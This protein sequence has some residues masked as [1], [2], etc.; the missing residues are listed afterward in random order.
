MAR[1]AKINRATL[2]YVTV[3]HATWIPGLR[4]AEDTW[5][6]SLVYSLVNMSVKTNVNIRKIEDRAWN[7]DGRLPW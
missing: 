4:F 3:V 1:P 7:G 5:A 6:V 2:R